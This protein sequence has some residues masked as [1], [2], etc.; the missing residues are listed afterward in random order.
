[1]QGD[2]TDGLAPTFAPALAPAPQPDSQHPMIVRVREDT[3]APDNPNIEELEIITEKVEVISHALAAQLPGHLTSNHSPPHLM[4]QL[5]RGVG[6]CTLFSVFTA[7]NSAPAHPASTD[8]CPPQ[9]RVLI[10]AP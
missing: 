7:S 9:A 5:H 6:S 1:M 10:C 4:T 2:H 8:N 3:T